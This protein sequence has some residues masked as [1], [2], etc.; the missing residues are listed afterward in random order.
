[1]SNKPKTIDEYLATLSD[2]KRA[3]LEKLRKTIR[4]AVPKAEECI[5]YQLPAFHLNGKMLIAFGAT[6]DHCALYPMSSSI[7]AAYQD[8]LKDYDTSKGTI[9]F[10]AAQKPV[11]AWSGVLRPKKR[12]TKMVPAAMAKRIAA[13]VPVGVPGYTDEKPMVWCSVAPRSTYRRLVPMAPLMK[14][15]SVKDFVKD[16]HHYGSEPVSTIGRSWRGD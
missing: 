11:S 10:Q 3:I 7:V 8:E 12:N 4:A 5:S 14:A 6:A 1:M 9:R 15:Y 16:P 13:G 2:D